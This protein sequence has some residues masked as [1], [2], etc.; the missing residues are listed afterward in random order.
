MSVRDDCTLVHVL[1]AAEGHA[2]CDECWS[3]TSAVT[4]QLY[5]LHGIGAQLDI[6]TE[7]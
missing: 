7:L 6:V 4:V 3:H 2:A 1:E 5:L